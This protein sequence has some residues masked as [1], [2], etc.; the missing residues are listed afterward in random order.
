MNQKQKTPLP[1]KRCFF[2]SYLKLLIL[3]LSVSLSTALIK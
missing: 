1:K 2:I 3:L